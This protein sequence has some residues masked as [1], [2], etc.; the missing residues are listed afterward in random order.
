MPC[1]KQVHTQ[2]CADCWAFW[3]AVAKR[4]EVRIESGSQKTI[5]EQ[6]GGKVLEFGK[7]RVEFQTNDHL[8]ISLDFLILNCKEGM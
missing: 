7:V 6:E 2:V 5:F 3:E 8:S 1:N 4:C